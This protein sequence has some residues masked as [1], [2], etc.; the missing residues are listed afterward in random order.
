MAPHLITTHTATDGVCH[1]HALQSGLDRREWREAIGYGKHDN[2]PLQQKDDVGRDRFRRQ[3]AIGE[4][5]GSKG[6]RE[7]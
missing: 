2:P 5:P 6:I 4:H 1:T 3:I 7:E